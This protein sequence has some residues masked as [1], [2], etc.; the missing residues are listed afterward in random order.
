MLQPATTSR[1][2]CSRLGQH[3]KLRTPL[4][5]R[6][7]RSPSLRYRGTGAAW[8]PWCGRREWRAI[9]VSL[10]TTKC[11]SVLSDPCS[12]SAAAVAVPSALPDLHF[13]ARPPVRCVRLHSRTCSGASHQAGLLG[14]RSAL[15]SKCMQFRL[16]QKQLPKLCHANANTGGACA[17]RPGKPL[18]PPR[19]GQ[20]RRLKPRLARGDPTSVPASAGRSS[21]CMTSHCR[22]KGVERLVR[23]SRVRRGQVGRAERAQPSSASCQRSPLL[24]RQRHGAR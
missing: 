15:T 3:C 4:P 21:I 12:R 14:R 18:P 6:P 16:H 10:R 22:T 24:Q 9:Q 20:Q 5:R 23:P 2:R 19:W 13:T 7:L 11:W 17:D 8:S 1:R